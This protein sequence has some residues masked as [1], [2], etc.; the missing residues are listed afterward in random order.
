[1]TC[2]ACLKIQ[3][4]TFD[5]NIPTTLPVAYIRVGISNI[6]IVGCEKH[7]KEVI[8]KLAEADK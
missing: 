8:N 6:A 2:D 7:V 3:R 1:M 5:K 4:H